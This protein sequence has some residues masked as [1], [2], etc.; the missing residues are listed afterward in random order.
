MSLG[1]SKRKLLVPGLR[2]KSA[3]GKSRRWAAGDRG[4]P[5]NR[6]TSSS[7][8]G[9]ETVGEKSLGRVVEV[10]TCAPLASAHPHTH[11]HTHPHNPK[12]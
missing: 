8:L 10:E 2:G 6:G 9:R 12:P 4:L 3:F 7:E 11:T 1:A 5:S